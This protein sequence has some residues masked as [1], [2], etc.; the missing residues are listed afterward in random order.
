MD[1]KE[2]IAQDLLGQRLESPRREPPDRSAVDIDGRTL[3]K[4]TQAQ[5]RSLAQQM[6]GRADR[7]L[8]TAPGLATHGCATLRPAPAPPA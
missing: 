2:A 1:T 8:Q 6:L 7:G 4:E 3:P 5:V